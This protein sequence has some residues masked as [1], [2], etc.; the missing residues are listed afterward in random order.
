MSGNAKGFIRQEA[1]E[2]QEALASHKGAHEGSGHEAVSKMRCA[3]AIDERN[4]TRDC[5]QKTPERGLWKGGTGKETV[6][7]KQW[8]TRD[9]SCWRQQALVDKMQE[10]WSTEGGDSG[11]TFREMGE[12]GPRQRRIPILLR[13]LR[14]IRTRMR[15]DLL[16]RSTRVPFM[17]N[18]L[19]KP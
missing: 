11:H 14:R 4:A 3:R 6:H 1:L 18:P 13:I 19:W 10:R 17:A 5:E 7:M 15:D 12:A 8:S 2:R 9:R 16:R